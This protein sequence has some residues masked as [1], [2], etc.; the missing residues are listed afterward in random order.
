MS[1]IVEDFHT[2]GFSI[3]AV[4]P[5]TG[6]DFTRYSSRH[7]VIQTNYF[8]TFGHDYPHNVIDFSRPQDNPFKNY[9]ENSIITFEQSCCHV[10]RGK[11]TTIVAQVVITT[12]PQLRHADSQRSLQQPLHDVTNSLADPKRCTV[13]VRKRKTLKIGQQ[14]VKICSKLQLSKLAGS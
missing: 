5:Y 14:I 2:L 1:D 7:H 6:M 10:N 13:T 4:I 12:K 9:H 8:P 11:N 3:L